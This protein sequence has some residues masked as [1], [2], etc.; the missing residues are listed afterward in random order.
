MSSMYQDVVE[1][2]RNKG[3][4]ITTARKNIV[5]TILN[6]DGPVSAI[7]I[8]NKLDESGDSVNKTT[9]YRE[10]D[11][12][13]KHG[14]LKLVYLKPG[15]VHYESAYLPHHHHL[16]CTNCES[17]EEIDCIID[18]QALL[19]KVKKRDFQLKGHKF[20]LYGLCVNCN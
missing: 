12:L 2:L 6:A 16:V 11:F 20:E 7:E 3:A 5:K 14:V 17:V 19:K 1:D 4:R 9:V 13:F 15:I 8:L 10:L 18:E